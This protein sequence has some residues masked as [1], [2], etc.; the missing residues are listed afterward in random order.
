MTIFSPSQR[1]TPID[2]AREVLPLLQGVAFEIVNM[3]LGLIHFSADTHRNQT[4]PR[5]VSL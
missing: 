2:P 1:A 4:W 3:L 5:R